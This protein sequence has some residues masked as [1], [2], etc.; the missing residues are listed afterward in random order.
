MVNIQLGTLLKC[1]VFTLKTGRLAVFVLTIK[2]QK[3]EN[4]QYIMQMYGIFIMLAGLCV[5]LAPFVK[6][7]AQL[8]I[9]CIGYGFFISA[10]YVLASVITVHVL[11]LY[12]FQTGYG[13]LCLVEGLGN[14]IG[15]A[16]VGRPQYYLYYH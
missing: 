15:P 9:L 1:V 12:D 8:M 2:K 10:N 6:T 5:F 13:I 11:C 7:Y 14:L 4:L 3:I 16:L